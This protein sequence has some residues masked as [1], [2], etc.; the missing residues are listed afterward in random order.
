MRARASLHV[1]RREREQLLRARR[2]ARAG[3]ALGELLPRF[4][5]EK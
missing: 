3:M 2:R 5:G 1:Q 4:F